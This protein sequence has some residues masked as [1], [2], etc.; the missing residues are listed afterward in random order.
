MT[1]ASRGKTWWGL[2]LVLVLV[3]LGGL[4]FSGLRPCPWAKPN[5][6]ALCYVSP[7]NPN[8][9]KEAPGKDPEGN[10]LV[11]VYATPASGPPAATGPAVAPTAKPE[12]KT[13]YWRCPMHPEI[14]R[15]APGK[16][17]KCGMD[18]VPVQT[19]E[20]RPRRL[21]LPVRPRLRQKSARSSTGCR[22]WTP[23]TSGTSPARPPAA[24]TWSRFMKRGGG[25][26]GHHQGVRRHHPVHGGENRQGGSPPLV[27]AHPGRGAGDL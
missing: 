9:I 6:K 14:V 5:P 22:P 4:Y 16:C 26:P 27:P 24:W 8:F 23:A 3:I 15:E 19:K 13:K 18:L 10:E 2:G 17:P 11:P 12:G 25:G 21:R 1:P 7:K 20:P